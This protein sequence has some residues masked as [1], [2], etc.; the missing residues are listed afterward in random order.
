M[1]IT[2]FTPTYNRAQTIPRLYRSLLNQS[3]KDFEWLVI[4]DGSSDGTEALVAGLIAESQI[5][6]RYL[7]TENGGKHR[8]I[9]KAL[10]MASG[11]IFFIVDS[12]DYLAENALARLLYWFSSIEKEKDSGRFA[13][14]AGLRGAPVS[15]GGGRTRRDVS[16]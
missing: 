3:V 16:R 8:A 4:D 9:N 2:V 11:D 12:D 13:G 5:S 1:T 10:D 14:V 6:I 7:K 15:M